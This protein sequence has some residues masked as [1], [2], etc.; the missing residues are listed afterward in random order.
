MV[1]LLNS[2]SG[3]LGRFGSISL[4]SLHVFLAL[5]SVLSSMLLGT[6]WL[7]SFASLILLETWASCWGFSSCHTPSSP[8]HSVFPRP[9]CGSPH[10][11]PAAP[12]SSREKREQCFHRAQIPKLSGMRSVLLPSQM[13]PSMAA[14]S[15]LILFFPQTLFTPSRHR[16]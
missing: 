5:L 16:L 9:L 10:P 7:S 4:C 11:Q 15:H 14:P 12:Q 3:P 1:Q 2:L 6:L 13:R 8:F